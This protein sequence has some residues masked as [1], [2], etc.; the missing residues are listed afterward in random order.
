MK[1]T[2]SLSIIIKNESK[3]ILKML[4]NVYSLLDYYVVVDTGSS[5][6]TQDIIKSFFEEKGIPGEIIQHKWKNIGDARNVALNATIGKVD[7]GFWIDPD[8][9]LIFSDDFDIESFKSKLSNYDGM[10]CPYFRGYDFQ[11][12]S[13]FSTT[14]PW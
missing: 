11:R 8:D 2:I 1:T 14:M 3:I 13:F 5:D 9:E 4:N 7:Y 10:Y 6:G 12:I